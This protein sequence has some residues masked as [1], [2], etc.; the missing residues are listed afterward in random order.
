MVRGR[1]YAYFEYFEGGRMVQKY[2]GPAGSAKS[3][4]A[5]LKYEYDLMKSKRNGLSDRMMEIR[6]G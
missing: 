1:L 6:G 5:A 3:K 2:C 4:S